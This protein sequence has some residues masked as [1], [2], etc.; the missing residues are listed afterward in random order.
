M[1]AIVIQKY[2]RGWW[3]RHFMEK[4]RAAIVLQKYFRGWKV[5]VAIFQYNNDIHHNIICIQNINDIF[6]KFIIKVNIVY[7]TV[8]DYDFTVN[9]Y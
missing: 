3:V 1:A 2:F 7:R 4:E 5:G 6:I 8:D 9:S